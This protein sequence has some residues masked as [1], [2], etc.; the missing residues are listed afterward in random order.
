MLIQ[1]GIGLIV[2]LGIVCLL[3]HS[4]A[5]GRIATLKEANEQVV[6]AEEQRLA[7]TVEKEFFRAAYETEN[8]KFRRLEKLYH[9]IVRG[10][11]SSDPADWWRDGGKSND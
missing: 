2:G 9:R 8:K 7:V 11:G 6:K 1:V 10:R 5:M 3:F 4:Y